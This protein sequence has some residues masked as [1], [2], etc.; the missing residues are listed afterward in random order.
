MS[1]RRDLIC[2][3]FCKS[4]NIDE[5]YSIQTELVQNGGAFERQLVRDY[6][7]YLIVRNTASEK[8][9]SAQLWHIT[10]VNELWLGDCLRTGS[11]IIEFL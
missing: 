11:E 6:T 4:C 7:D 2:V 9:R 10:I 3:F 5:R 8:Y 1:Q